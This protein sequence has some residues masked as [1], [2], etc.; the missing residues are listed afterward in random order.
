MERLPA[1]VYDDPIPPPG[2]RCVRSVDDKG[3]LVEYYA[4]AADVF[5]VMMIAA[6][7]VRLALKM[8]RE[9]LDAPPPPSEHALKLLA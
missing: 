5:D 4:A 9:K 2:M 8:Q 6:M 3:Y 7:E 1:G